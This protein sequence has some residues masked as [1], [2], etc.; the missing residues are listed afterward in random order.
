MTK[1]LQNLC[2]LI[3]AMAGCVLG[4]DGAL[5]AAG[6]RPVN[7]R[8]AIHQASDV[9][10]LE[11]ELRA[12]LHAPG[13]RSET[14]TT[15]SRGFRSQEID[16]GKKVIA[17]LGDSYA[18]GFGV[19]DEETNPAVIAALLP[20]FA[21]VNTGVNGYNIEQETLTY[22]AKVRALHPVVTILEFTPNDGDRKA[23]FDG[24]IRERTGTGSWQI[25]GP[26]WW[27]R[28]SPLVDIVKRGFLRM[29]EPLPSSAPFIVEWPASELTH[30][31]RWFTRLSADIGNAPKLLVLWPDR[32]ERPE[33]FNSVRAMAHTHGWEILDLTE[34]LGTDFER[35]GWDSH[36][37]A[38][39]QK[40]AGEAIAATLREMG[41][42]SED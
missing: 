15:D 28:T 5:R 27:R 33:T 2:L 22:E 13:F 30:F 34:Q 39:T 1:L 10:D 11:Y 16:D 25:H 31:G 38:R 3:F 21:V 40:L 9:P 24:D 12:D 20:A 6:V 14:V 32:A 17:I 26:R 41:I 19:R 42:T 7:L 37:S 36:P 35:L 18:F 8:P 29:R 4:L 23:T